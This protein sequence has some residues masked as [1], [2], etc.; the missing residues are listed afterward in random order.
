MLACL[1]LVPIKQENPGWSNKRQGGIRRNSRHSL[2]DYRHI[3]F[4]I[5]GFKRINLSPLKS[6]E[7]LVSGG[8]E[9]CLFAQILLSHF[10]MR[11]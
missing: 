8:I 7:N 11:Q 9:V 5:S 2:T 6:S 4:L 10:S 3:S 1:S